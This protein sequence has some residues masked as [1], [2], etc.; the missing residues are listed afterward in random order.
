MENQSWRCPRCKKANTYIKEA[1][2]KHFC[3]TCG[4]KWAVVVDDQIILL[5]KWV[6]QN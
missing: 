1:E 6:H 3:R 2:C 5:D 4:Y